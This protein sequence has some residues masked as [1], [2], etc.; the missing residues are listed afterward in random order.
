M[1]TFWLWRGNDSHQLGTRFFVHKGNNI[2]TVQRVEFVTDRIS[3]S[4]CVCVCL[5]VVRQLSS[6]LDR[7]TVEGS[8]SHTHTHTHTHTHGRTPL[9][10]LSVCQRGRYLYNTQK[11]QETNIRILNGIRTHEPSKQAY[12]GLSLRPYGYRDGLM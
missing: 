1:N 3:Y 5:C 6:V 9:N 7:L 8:R 12:S 11:T 4:L 10:E 2:L